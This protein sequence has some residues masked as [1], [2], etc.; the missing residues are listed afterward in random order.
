MG[1]NGDRAVNKRADAKANKAAT[2]QDDGWQGYVNVE[3][4]TGDKEGVSE[5]ASMMDDVWATI[6]DLVDAGYKLSVSCDATHNT[7]NA[8]LTCKNPVDK[9]RG[10]TLSGRGGMIVLALAS[11]VYKHRVLLNRDWTTHQSYSGGDRGAG[12]ID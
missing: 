8:S 12:Y 11:L 2:R 6:W 10:L 1:A 7:Y 3:L 4:S 9:N 5:L